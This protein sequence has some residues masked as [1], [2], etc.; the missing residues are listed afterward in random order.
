MANV[1]VCK[2]RGVVEGADLGGALLA[3]NLKKK[4]NKSFFSLVN[5]K[6]QHHSTHTF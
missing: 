4:I 3:S 6:R 1:T 2:Q 5:Q